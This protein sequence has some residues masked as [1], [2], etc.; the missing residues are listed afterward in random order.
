MIVECLVLARGLAGRM[1]AHARSGYPQEVCGLVA[2][3]NGA[4]YEIYPGRNVATDPKNRFQ[5]D[6]D[7]LALQAAFADRDLDLVAIYHSHPQDR[8]YHRLATSA[9]LTTRRPFT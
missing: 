1:I 7:T 5:L 2:G 8:L 6:P 4:G 3:R 9:R